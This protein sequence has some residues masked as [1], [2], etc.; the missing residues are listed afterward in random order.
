MCPWKYIVSY[1]N[2]KYPFYRAEVKCTCDK[3]LF[4]NKNAN[5][6]F[7]YGCQPVYKHMPVLIKKE[8]G[9]DGYYKWFPSTEEV[10]FACVCTSNKKWFPFN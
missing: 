7:D 3:C 6:H 4:R 2:D 5:I 1:R 8:C 10:N 9:L